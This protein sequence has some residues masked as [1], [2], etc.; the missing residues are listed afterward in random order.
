MSIESSPQ[1][2]MD[3][4]DPDYNLLVEYVYIGCGNGRVQNLGNNRVDRR[5]L[6]GKR[7]RPPPKRNQAPEKMQHDG[8]YNK[9]AVGNDEVPWPIPPSDSLNGGPHVGGEGQGR[10]SSMTLGNKMIVGRGESPS[11]APTVLKTNQIIAE[12]QDEQ[13][14]LGESENPRQGFHYA[15]LA[16][17][18]RQ[19]GQG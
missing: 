13:Q 4:C 8:S 9:I 17:P 16:I 7:S 3:Y 10:V 11:S 14:G 5:Q 6:R 12:G 15:L 19:G 2:M 1:M 18:N